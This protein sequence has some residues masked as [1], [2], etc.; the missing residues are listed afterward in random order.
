M[1]S[2]SVPHPQG[3]GLLARKDL[4]HLV[5]CTTGPEPLNLGVIVG[6]NQ[7]KLVRAAVLVLENASDRLARGKVCQA[8]EGNP[9]IRADLVIVCRVPKCE[10][11]HALFLQVG[12]CRGRTQSLM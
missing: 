4:G 2:V 9:V 8:K 7:F 5:Q 6:V 3:E 11:E 12:F 10:G 1:D